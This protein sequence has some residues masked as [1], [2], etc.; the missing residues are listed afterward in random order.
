MD[1]IDYM[2]SQLKYAVI[3]AQIWNNNEETLLAFKNRHVYFA[4]H[5]TCNRRLCA[6]SKILLM[7]RMCYKDCNSI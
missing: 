1:V 3:E 7:M 5:N 4:Y 6:E 2:S